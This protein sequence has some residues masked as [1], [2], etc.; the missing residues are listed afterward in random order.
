MKW[1][2]EALSRY[3]KDRNLTRAEMATQLGVSPSMLSLICLGKR[4]PGVALTKRIETV[5]GIP[6]HVLRPDVYEAAQ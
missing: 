5:T 1:R 2:M 4:H 3:M 6:R